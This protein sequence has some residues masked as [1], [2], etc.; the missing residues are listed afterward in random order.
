MNSI[1]PVF[2]ER[3]VP[4]EQVIALEQSGYYPIIIAQ[5]SFQDGSQDSFVRFQFSDKEREAIAAGADLVIS[6][7]YHSKFTPIGLQ[8]AMPGEYPLGDL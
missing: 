7:P 1:S 3:E 2:T 4:V 8:L 5:I 6:Q